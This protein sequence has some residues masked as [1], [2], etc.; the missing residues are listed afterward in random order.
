M[1]TP[2]IPSPPLPDC[3]NPGTAQDDDPRL[4]PDQIAA[5]NAGPSWTGGKVADQP[6]PMIRRWPSDPTPRRASVSISTYQGSIVYWAKH[7]HVR[8]SEESNPFYSV[9]QDGKAGWRTCWDEPQEHKGRALDRS[10]FR[11]YD[12]AKR[13]A[14]TMLWRHFLHHRIDWPYLEDNEAPP[15]RVFVYVREGD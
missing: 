3:Q 5:A 12:Q 10:D 11:T 15:H 8:I 4:T 13:W 1:I 7:Y 6:Q 2:T 9:D 14:L